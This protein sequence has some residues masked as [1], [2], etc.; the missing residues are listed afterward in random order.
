MKSVLLASLALPCA[1]RKLPDG[2]TSTFAPAAQRYHGVSKQQGEGC[3][4][5]EIAVGW[6][7]LTVTLKRSKALLN[8]ISS[9]RIDRLR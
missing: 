5:E 6:A 9:L 8:C 7:Q 2:Y 4:L 1:A 3:S